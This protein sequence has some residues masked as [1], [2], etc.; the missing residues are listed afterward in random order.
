MHEDKQQLGDVIVTGYQRIS[1]ERS[2]AAF[3][4]VDSEQLNR[5]MHSDLASSLEGQVAGLR[6]NINSNTGDMSPILRGVGTF[7]HDVGTEPL[8]VVDDMPTNL[9]LSE[10]NPYNV[11]SITVLKDAAA[12]SIYGALAANGVIVVAT[13]RAKKRR[14]AREH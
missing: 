3:G 14:C 8:I 6:M 5:Q 10:I 13:M 7:S 4:F 9:R 12:A 11:E 2:T 1:R